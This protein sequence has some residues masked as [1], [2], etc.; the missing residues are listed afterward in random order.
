MKMN[1]YTFPTYLFLLLLFSAN[2]SPAQGW[3]K[4]IEDPDWWQI[5]AICQAPDSGFFLAGERSLEWQLYV[6]KTDKVGNMLWDKTY[7]P[8]LQHPVVATVNA[9]PDGGIVVAG[10]LDAQAGNYADNLYAMR[11]NGSGEVVWRTDFM[12]LGNASGQIEGTLL[13]ADGSFLFTGSGT[14]SRGGAALLSVNGEVLW[15]KTF[16]G[17]APFKAFEVGEGWLLFGGNYCCPFGTIISK[18]DKQGNLLWSKEE[19]AY[20]M[21]ISDMFQT[22]D[23]NF[24]FIARYDPQPFII[25]SPRTNIG[26]LKTNQELDTLWFKE[27][28]FGDDLPDP[29]L[30]DHRYAHFYLSQTGNFFFAGYYYWEAYDKGTPLYVACVS[31]TGELKWEKTVYPHGKDVHLYRTFCPTQDG[32]IIAAGMLE[33][34][35]SFGNFEDF[36]LAKFDSLGWLS[37]SVLQGRL[38][39]DE[40]KSCAADSSESS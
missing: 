35:V 5:E 18:I 38:F 13:N 25:N 4:I 19:I 9:L 22:S 30:D 11:L 16:Q 20:G 28:H 37:P 31:P 6:A 39:F 17:W 21:R 40:N 3:L 33:P 2:P 29:R 26:I 24:A 1:R 34:Y 15:T 36:F 7:F 14:G 12:L 32:G 27:M 8:N 10:S 23:S